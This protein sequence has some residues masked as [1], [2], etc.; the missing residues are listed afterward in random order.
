MYIY[1][2]LNGISEI[3]DVSIDSIRE[4][5]TLYNKIGH[6][7][8]LTIVRNFDNNP[9]PDRQRLIRSYCLFNETGHSLSYWQNKPKRLISPFGGASRSITISDANNCKT[10]NLLDISGQISL[11]KI[12]PDREALYQKCNE[13]FLKMLD[14]GGVE[15]VEMAIQNYGNTFAT[16]K[17]I[18]Y[19]E[20]RDYIFGN[21]S[22]EECIR[23]ATQKTR[24]YAKS[25]FTW[26]RNKI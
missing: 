8:F 5:E 18:G 19:N 10:L 6:D 23:I 17:I 1:T 7:E 21:I 13:R 15:E 16:N 3:P 4:S 26:L 12:I 14:C 24:N 9:Y 11:I 2:L 25:Q 20:V 22:R